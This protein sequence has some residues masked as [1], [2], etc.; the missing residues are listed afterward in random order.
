MMMMMTSITSLE[1]VI[2]V[3]TINGCGSVCFPSNT[4]CIPS[5]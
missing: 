4:K 1:I 5:S 3:V 2:I